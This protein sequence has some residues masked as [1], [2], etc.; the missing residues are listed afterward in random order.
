MYFRILTHVIPFLALYNVPLSKC[1]P[2]PF[3][4]QPKKACM[5]LFIPFSIPP[6]L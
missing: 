1:T 4:T 5:A 2:I 6:K 3:A